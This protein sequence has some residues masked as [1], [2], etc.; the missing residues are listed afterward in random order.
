MKRAIVILLSVMMLF[1]LAACGSA[2]ESEGFTVDTVTMTYVK[3]PLNVPSIVEK[4]KGSF[5]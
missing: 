5:E 1:S 2:G 4:A 3:S